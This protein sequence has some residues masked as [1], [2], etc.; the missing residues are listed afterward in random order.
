MIPTLLL[1][2]LVFGRWWKITLAVATIGWCVAL[3]ADHTITLSSLG[4]AALLGFLNTGVGVG[5]HQTILTKLRSRH[6]T[7]QHA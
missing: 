3:L 1:A 2:G 6:H 4:A 7:S 5:V